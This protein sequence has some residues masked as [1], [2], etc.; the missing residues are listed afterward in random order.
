VDDDRLASIGRVSGIGGWLAF[1]CFGQLLTTAIAAFRAPST[2]DDVMGGSWDLGAISP[3][4]R[5]TLLLEMTINFAR[6]ILPAIGLYLTFKRNRYTPRFW[7]AFTA[8]I[9]LLA[10]V[11]IAAGAVIQSQLSNRLGRDVSSSNELNAALRENLRT[12]A[13]ALIWALYWARSL[14]VRSTFGADGI[15]RLIG[16]APR[17]S[18]QAGAPQPPEALAES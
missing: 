8:L 7:L 11:D 1:F 6:I 16:P 9:G 18:A 4:L 15:D 2:I 14:R 13:W 12:V 3:P 10:A 17:L 5:P